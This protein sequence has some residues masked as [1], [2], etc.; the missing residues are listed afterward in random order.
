[1]TSKQREK[2]EHEGAGIARDIVLADTTEQVRFVVLDKNSR[3]YGSLR[4]PIAPKR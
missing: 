2:T 1:M 4:I 3:R